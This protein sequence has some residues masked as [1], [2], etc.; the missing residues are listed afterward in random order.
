MSCFKP[1]D[2][3]LTCN[4]KLRDANNS[5]FSVIYTDLFLNQFAV[6]DDFQK[7]LGKLGIEFP[8]Q[9]NFLIL[10]DDITNVVLYRKLSRKDNVFP[11]VG[12]VLKD[13]YE[14]KA[15]K[16]KI[17]K[18]PNRNAFNL[19]AIHSFPNKKAKTVVLLINEYKTFFVE[20]LLADN[21][22]KS[23]IERIFVI[24]NS[25]VE[26][27]FLYTLD[28]PFKV[29]LF[30]DVR[31]A[32]EPKAATL[33]NFRSTHFTLGPP[34]KRP[35]LQSDGGQ[36][37]Q[38]EVNSSVVEYVVVNGND[39]V[40]DVPA[41]LETNRVYIFDISKMR[42]SL[43][44][45]PK[46]YRLFKMF[47][48]TY[49]FNGAKWS[50]HSSAQD[51]DCLYEF[52]RHFN[53]EMLILAKWWPDNETISLVQNKLRVWC[54][55]IFG[56]I[57]TWFFHCDIRNLFADAQV[58]GVL[59]LPYLQSRPLLAGGGQIWQTSTLAFMALARIGIGV[60]IVANTNIKS[61]DVGTKEVSGYYRH[62]F[63]IPFDTRV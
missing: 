11:I 60:S 50:V 14:G 51:G 5:L 29:A 1:P 35:A 37:Q 19:D 12:N 62:L 23:T 41:P 39:I 54:P 38:M 33:C 63:R 43:A 48:Y 2:A 34:T 4:V 22:N 17:I 30:N 10:C 36:P 15:E 55:Q 25:L 42:K 16:D 24:L 7:L 49:C 40:N 47:Y 53:N 56:P 20:R 59:P 28:K 9:Y 3:L 52:R 44:Q 61:D 8:L 26:F 21:N 31:A 27:P 18:K 6:E 13:R 58:N 46:I 45:T 57:N 32:A